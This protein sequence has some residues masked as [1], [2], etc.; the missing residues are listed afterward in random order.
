[1]DRSNVRT[2]WRIASYKDLLPAVNRQP[3][4]SLGENRTKGSGGV[5]FSCLWS[6]QSLRSFESL[7]C[8]VTSVQ[9]QNKWSWGPHVH[10][11]AHSEIENCYFHNACWASSVFK[12]H[13]L[14]SPWA[15]K[16][17]KPAKFCCFFACSTT[18]VS[19][20]SLGPIET[21]R[22]PICCDLSPMQTCYVLKVGQTKGLNRKSIRK[23]TSCEK[24]S[25]PKLHMCPLQ[26]R[27]ANFLAHKGFLY[28]VPFLRIIFRFKAIGKPSILFPP[29]NS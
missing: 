28:E 27:L 6:L 10:E 8:F 12:A 9:L 14:S 11:R 22:K 15:L 18:R 25:I 17:L 4:F 7:L 29:G 26:L 2:I 1:M 3:G 16:T 19:M 13:A 23:I 24:L 21:Y 20:T 5:F